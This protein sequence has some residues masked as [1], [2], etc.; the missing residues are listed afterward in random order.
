MIQKQSRA[1]VSPVLHVNPSRVTVIAF[2]LPGI[3][4]RKVQRSIECKKS[5]EPIIVLSRA[6][7]IL[8]VLLLLLFSFACA[9][10]IRSVC[11]DF[12]FPLAFRLG[13]L[14][15][16]RMYLKLSNNYF[17]RVDNISYFLCKFKQLIHKKRGW[18]MT[19]RVRAVW[20]VQHMSF[21]FR[22]SPCLNVTFTFLPDLF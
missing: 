3:L 20:Y 12:T 14:F 18:N 11:D 22:V 6:R 8:S 2:K 16:N 10:F 21:L 9:A 19:A 1:S 15:P 13:E 7:T 4:F 17:V 5:T